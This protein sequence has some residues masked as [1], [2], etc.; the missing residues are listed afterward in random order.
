M[1]WAAFCAGCEGVAIAQ[2]CWPERDALRPF[3]RANREAW[4]TPRPY[5][6]KDNQAPYRYIP[7]FTTGAIFA[8]GP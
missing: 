8:P 3:Q 5:L 6:A 1:A 2:H 4:G 7:P